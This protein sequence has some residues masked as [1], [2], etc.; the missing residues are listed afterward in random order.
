M[1]MSL[2]QTTQ[3]LKGM[4]AIFKPLWFVRARV[5]DWD[6]GDL[7]S[8]LCCVVAQIRSSRAYS[9]WQLRM[10]WF[11]TYPLGETGGKKAAKKTQGARA[12][13]TVKLPRRN[14]MG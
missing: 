11:R 6:L 13:S 10:D 8:N 1:E 7:G 4:S 9:R 12:H 5:L 3:P 14:P 2:G